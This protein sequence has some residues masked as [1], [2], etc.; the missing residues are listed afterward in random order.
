MNIM[1]NRVALSRR[2][3]LAGSG[4]LVVAFSMHAPALAQ[5]LPGPVPARRGTDNKKVD[6]YFV[7][8][9][10]GGVTLY[11]GK[12]DLGTGH[13]IA[14][15]QIVADELGIA[16][17][18]IT[19]IEGDTHLTPDQGSTSGSNGMM[20]GGVQTRQAAAT[21]RAALIKLG[22]QKLNLPEAELDTI[23]GEVRPKK[24]GAGVTFAALLAN[25]SFNLELDPKAPR[26]RPSEYKYVGKHVK[27]PDMPGKAT[28]THV[29]MHDFKVEGMLHG[30]S[31]YPPRPGA[32]LVSVDETSVADIP[33]VRVVRINN[34]LGVVAEREWHAHKAARQLKAVWEG[35]GIPTSSAE[36]QS[37]LRASGPRD[38]EQTI[39]KKGEFAKAWP[40]AA[41]KV[42]SDFYWPM[43]SHASLGPSC[44]IADVRS[45]GATI[46]TAS[47]GTHKFA[48]AFDGFLQLPK[49][50]VRQIYLDGAGCYGMNGH[51]DAAAD[52]AILSRAVGKPVRVQWTRE[53]EHA[54][55]PKGPPQTLTVEAGLDADGKI[56]SWRSQMWIPR[57]TP[58]LPNVP[59]V[60]P[61]LAGLPQTMGIATGSLFQG[62]TPVYEIPNM[63]TQLHFLRGAPV[64]TS[65]LRAPGKIGNLMAVE[66]VMDE[67]A[68]L[69]GKDPVAFRLE[70]LKEPRSID[71]LKKAAEIHGWQPRVQPR[72]DGKGRGIAFT[73]YKGNETWVALAIDVEVD[74]ASGAIKVVRAS[75]AH[76]CG[77]IISPDGVKAQVEGCI[78]QTISRTLHEETKFDRNQITGVDWAS[79]PVLTFAE[80]PELNIALIDRPDQRP[81]GA[82]EAA[83]APVAAAIANAVFDATG[84]RLRSAPFTPQRVRSA[85]AESATKAG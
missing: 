72:L 38:G 7:I 34:Y 52:A 80:V 22:A 57:P 24:G 21:A 9:A 84:V 56:T 10:D 54:W 40:G 58:K 3:F 51:D 66:T 12:V 60:G 23:D 49:G 4:S 85:M 11:S 25:Q 17:E 6:S 44:A 29:W 70:Y 14:L 32:K 8:N 55:D 50:S 48:D 45:D 68:L 30:R 16:I 73:H 69:A 64:R 59:L 82:G 20:R 78:I 37:Y 28:G 76:D 15:P 43:Q 67:L 79:Y 39:D 2:A 18:R 74:K 63:E 35:G 36:A 83:T 41:K 81:L 46:W 33:G 42:T 47:Q 71:V 75:C 31:V 19:M 62:A 27:R 5:N 65:P 26:R 1:Q 61:E 53:D 13:R 77:Q